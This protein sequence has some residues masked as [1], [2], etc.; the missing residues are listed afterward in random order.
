MASQSLRK[1]KMKP[2]FFKVLMKDFSTR[3][4]IPPA[5]MK[6]FGK[7]LAKKATLETDYD[8]SWEV[9]V[10]KLGNKFYLNNGW[11][12]FVE[13]NNLETGDF[14]VLKYFAH[15]SLFK[16]KI[17]GKTCCEKKLNVVGKGKDQINEQGR[18]K[19]KRNE[20]E[21]D[22]NN[23]KRNE[24]EFVRSKAFKSDVI[25]ID[26][27]SSSSSDDDDEEI[28]KGSIQKR[29][30]QTVWLKTNMPQDYQ[31]HIEFKS[32][33]PFFQLQLKFSTTNFYLYIP[34]GFFMEHLKESKRIKLK[35]CEKT[36]DMEIHVYEHERGTK[37]TQGARVT[38][39]W[40]R[41][42]KEQ[43]LEMDDVCF[44]EMI[45]KF[46]TDFVFRVH[47]YRW[48][49]RKAKFSKII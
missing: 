34:K 10:E 28:R 45:K 44:F 20:E 5:F 1:R 31:N 12:K 35:I 48:D 33:N 37:R 13:D 6:E 16:V 38:Q 26:P 24:T 27:D 40:K 36:W 46:D 30:A 29:K 19:R 25:K 32:E 15:Y 14:L 3:L 41:A 42:V 7:H 22:N 11:S 21:D 17:Y 9:G 49:D 39:G 4:K 47:V 2:S 8:K 23:V 43:N 18:R